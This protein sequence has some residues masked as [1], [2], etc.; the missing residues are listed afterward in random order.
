[1]LYCWVIGSFYLKGH[2]VFIFK[3]QAVQEELQ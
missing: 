3:D 1:M 2:G